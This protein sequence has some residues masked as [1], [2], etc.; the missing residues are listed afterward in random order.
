MDGTIVTILCTGMAGLSSAV[1]YL[2]KQQE[3]H[4]KETRVTLKEC[5]ED[6]QKL[7]GELSGIKAKQ[8][9]E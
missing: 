5:E 1:V 2:W 8:A 9:S 4:F 7:W 6:R 3:G